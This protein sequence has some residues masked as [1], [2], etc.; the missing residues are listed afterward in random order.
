LAEAEDFCTTIAILDQGKIYAQGTPS[1]LI[2]S[3]KEARNLED[4]FIS[5]TGKDLRDDI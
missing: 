4:V 5:L 2:A 3:T 1:G